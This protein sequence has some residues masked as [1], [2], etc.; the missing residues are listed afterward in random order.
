[1]AT[2]PNILAWKILWTEEPGRLQS[3][4]SQELD[5]TLRLNHHHRLS[6]YHKPD[7]AQ[8]NNVSLSL[9]TL[10]PSAHFSSLVNVLCGFIF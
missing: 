4:G 10:N 5:A 6:P 1:M 9:S 2:H 8:N 3:M 7:F